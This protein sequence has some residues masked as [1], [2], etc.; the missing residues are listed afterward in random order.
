[1]SKKAYVKVVIAGDGATGK[2]TLS[3]RLSGTLEEQ[4]ETEMTTGIDFHTASFSELDDN[5]IF[6]DLGG[7]EHFRGFQR[8]FFKSANIIILVFDI[9]LIDTFFNISSWLSLINREEI[10]QIYLL[11]NKID[12]GNRAVQRAQAEEYAQEHNLKYFEVSAL[13]NEGLQTL[14]KDLLKIITSTY[15][16]DKEEDQNSFLRNS[17]NQKTLNRKL[18]KEKLSSNN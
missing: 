4:Q 12:I 8:S 2:T 13:K 10:S 9:T 1:M 14:K 17:I 5:L 15:K 18:I 16:S 6:W 3:K 11:G 7:Q